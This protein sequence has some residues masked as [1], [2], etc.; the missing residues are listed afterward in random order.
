MKG[1]QIRKEKGKPAVFAHYIIFH[2]VNSQESIKILELIN[3]FGMIGG[4]KIKMQNQLYF[5][6]IGKN[7]QKQQLKQQFLGHGGVCL[8]SQHSVS[9]L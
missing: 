1:I 2:V 3:T 8:I 6:N 4:Y 9:L 7:N 5:Y